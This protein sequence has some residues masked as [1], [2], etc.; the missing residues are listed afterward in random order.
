[1][2]V[3]LTQHSSQTDGETSRCN[4]CGGQVIN[5]FPFENSSTVIHCKICGTE[6]IRPLPTPEQ[7]E[8]YYANYPTTKTPEEQIHYLTALSVEA[9]QF[10]ISKMNLRNN[11][12]GCLRFLE[13]GFG[14]GAG[15]FAGYKLGFQSYG[16]D[17]DPA[18]VSSAKA[19][20]EKH[21]YAVTC[22]C[23]DV[24]LLR[25]RDIKFDIVKAS[26]ILE[27]VIDP[28]R[29]LSDIAQAQPAGGYLILECPNNKAAFWFLKNRVRKAFNRLNFYNSLKLQ[30]HLW[31]YTKKSLPLVLRKA[32]YRVLFFRDYAVGNVIFH[33]Q[34]ALWY[35][36]LRDG[37]RQ[38]LRYRR[39]HPLIYP[40]VRVFD[41]LSS[42]LFRMGTGL[43]VLCQKIES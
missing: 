10:Y 4:I 22:I 21:T 19:F 27:H 17:L 2:A 1:M 37:F 31:G 12:P 33:P 32:G 28:I 5:L 35:P 38:S 40:S 36:T 25:T 7:I 13:I 42:K 6:S 9:L 14:N 23:G 34:T 43:A 29:F 26:H 24:T 15:L 16:I 39:W 11:P 3:S 20:A 30:E 41:S 8:N 18:S